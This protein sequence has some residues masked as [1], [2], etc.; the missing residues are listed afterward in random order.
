M[1]WDVNSTRYT[2]QVDL[3]GGQVRCVNSLPSWVS[4]TCQ[5]TTSILVK[6]LY[7]FNKVGYFDVVFL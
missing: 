1:F 5:K 7:F 4:R 2:G 6:D 3:T